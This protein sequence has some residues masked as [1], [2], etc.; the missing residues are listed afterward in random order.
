MHFWAT[1]LLQLNT[2]TGNKSGPVPSSACPGQHWHP[3]S[4]NISLEQ[5]SAT[6]LLSYQTFAIAFLILLFLVI[7]LSS[8]SK[9]ICQKTIDRKFTKSKEFVPIWSRRKSSAHVDTIMQTWDLERNPPGLESIAKS[10]TSEQPSSKSFVTVSEQF[11]FR[12][13]L[14]SVEHFQRQS[15]A[16]TIKKDAEDDVTRQT[17]SL[18]VSSIRTGGFVNNEVLIRNILQNIP[19]SIQVQRH[20]SRDLTRPCYLKENSNQHSIKNMGHSALYDSVLNEFKESL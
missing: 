19:N 18:A 3:S 14:Q 10:T 1:N 13:A 7:I 6:T 15:E 4:E 12:S 16:D 8:L 2:E 5:D 9:M 17:D 20:Q 11:S